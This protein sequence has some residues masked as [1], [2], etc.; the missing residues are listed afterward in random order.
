MGIEDG[1]LILYYL[2]KYKN[3]ECNG[4]CCFR[5]GEQ[6][7]ESLL[8]LGVFFLITFGKFE[9]TK[10]TGDSMGYTFD[11][12]ETTGNHG[13]TSQKRGL[14]RPFSCQPMIIPMHISL[15]Q[16][17]GHP[18]NCNCSNVMTDISSLVQSDF[19]CFNNLVAQL[20]RR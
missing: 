3:L 20:G 13:C 14:R 8:W 12:K 4:D 11:L 17:G 1:L 18:R 2:L 6:F 5:D 9:T 15:S 16:D 7:A 10:S 19:T